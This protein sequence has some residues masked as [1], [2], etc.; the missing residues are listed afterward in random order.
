[1]VELF[2]EHMN[3]RGIGYAGCARE[4]TVY[5]AQFKFCLQ[6]ILIIIDVTELFR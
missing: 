2:S 1:M 5:V 3:I 4:N 6:I